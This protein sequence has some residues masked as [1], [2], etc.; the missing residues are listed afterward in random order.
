[1][2]SPDNGPGY[3]SSPQASGRHRSEQ[4]TSWQSTPPPPQGPPAPPG[5]RPDPRQEQPRP[6]PDRF[7]GFVP[8]NQPQQQSA[9]PQTGAP[10]RAPGAGP[11]RA[12][13][14][15]TGQ[16]DLADVLAKLGTQQQAE[17]AGRRAPRRL[18]IIGA[19]VVVAL[20]VLAGAGYGIYRYVGSDRYKSGESATIER[21]RMT[22]TNITCGYVTP[23]FG[24]DGKP[25]GQYC[26][27]TVKATNN[28]RFTTVFIDPQTW[29]AQLDVDLSVTPVQSFLTGYRVTVNGEQTQWMRLTYDIPEGAHIRSLMMRIETHT[30][31]VNVS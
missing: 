15:T 11:Q 18:A 5:S 7:N 13:G 12:P 1:M 19:I 9:A 20:L 22:V 3:G 29:A 2:T 14:R 30:D 16:R 28:A 10:Q 17:Q 31:W 8:R 23:P 4:L 26:G 21:V 6:E 25:R 24:D 27:V